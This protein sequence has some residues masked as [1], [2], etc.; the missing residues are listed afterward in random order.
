MVYCDS[1]EAMRLVTAAS[2][3]TGEPLRFSMAAR[4]LC[5]DGV[6]QPFLLGRP[7]LAVPCGGDRTHGGTQDD[8]LVAYVVFS[9]RGRY[10]YLDDFLGCDP[11]YVAVALAVLLRQARR[12]GAEAVVT[13]FLGAARYARLLRHYGFWQRP[14]DWKFMIYGSPSRETTDAAGILDPENWYLTRA[15]LDTDF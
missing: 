13:V 11:K 6:A 4:G 12:E 9:R 10:V 2:W 14:S 8:E 1:R 5:A 15:D 7:V 3:T